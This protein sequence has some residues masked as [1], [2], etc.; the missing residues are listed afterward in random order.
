MKRGASSKRLYTSRYLERADQS[1]HDPLTR[2]PERWTI[3]L[4][5]VPFSAQPVRYVSER[6]AITGVGQRLAVCMEW[7]GA[8]EYLTPEVTG[9]T[10]IDQ[11]ADN[12]QCQ[13]LIQAR[14]FAD[15]SSVCAAPLTESQPPRPKRD[16][17]PITSLHPAKR[18][19][20]GPD[21]CL[22]TCRGPG[23]PRLRLLYSSLSEA[24]T[25]AK[26]THQPCTA[27]NR[28]ARAT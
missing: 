4:A 25:T 8:T 27:N 15:K 24:Y 20:R 22:C 16:P 17:R 9:S 6:C 1:D 28:V 7:S 11:G 14:F 10:V 26:M 2:D 19:A 5:N 18:P 13:S 12:T 3:R 21:P 23:R